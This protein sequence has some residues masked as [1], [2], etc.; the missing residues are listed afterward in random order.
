M[1]GAQHCINL[2]G[3]FVTWGFLKRDLDD[4]AT[5]DV[6]NVPYTVGFK[7]CMYTVPPKYGEYGNTQRVPLA[8]ALA[9]A[10]IPNV[11][12]THPFWRRSS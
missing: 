6:G 12:A 4:L 1:P 2:E 8:N 3:C 10:A 9:R 5:L 7:V 11:N